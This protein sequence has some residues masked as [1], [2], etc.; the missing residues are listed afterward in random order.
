MRL[1]LCGINEGV[2]RQTGR[3]SASNVSGGP[4]AP[5][6]APPR[7]GLLTWESLSSSATSTAQSLLRSSAESDTSDTSV[8]ASPP[9]RS[10][11]ELEREAS[12]EAAWRPAS[13]QH[14]L[15][16]FL[17]APAARRQKTSVRVFGCGAEQIIRQNE[18]SR[19]VGCSLTVMGIQNVT[20]VPRPSPSDSV[21][22]S[23]PI[24][25]ARRRQICG[26]TIRSV[27]RVSNQAACTLA[28]SSDANR[29]HTSL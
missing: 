6:P 9:R 23:P 16:Q 13:G 8:G 20:V 10:L 15:K 27:K 25:L 17:S 3:Q 28:T 19:A 18:S 24:A 7:R 29:V 2:V 26:G 22:M 11:V 21:K 14:A 5:P 4:A 1:V 12:S